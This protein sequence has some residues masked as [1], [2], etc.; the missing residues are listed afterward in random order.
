MMTLIK[1]QPC[2]SETVLN[3]IEYRRQIITKRDFIGMFQNEAT[4]HNTINL[5]DE[6][7]QIK[8]TAEFQFSIVA[9]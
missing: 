1:S 2:Y 9:P 3:R 4:L 7:T 8:Y 5:W 6:M